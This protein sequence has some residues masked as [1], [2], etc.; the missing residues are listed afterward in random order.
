M[1]E[2]I[3]LIDDEEDIRHFLS[4]TLE[5]E[6]YEVIT[7]CNGQE[8]LNLFTRQ[9][10]DLVITDMRM[11][12]KD[13]MA[14]LK[15]IKATGSDVD[16]IM[17]TGHSDEN[18][19]IACLRQGVY[20]YLRK[21][22]EDLDLLIASV[23]RAIQKRRLELH[24]KALLHRLE[25]LAIKDSLTGL[26]NYRYL[27]IA[28]DQ[29]ILRSARF[30]HPFCLLMIDLDDFKQVNDTYGH[31]CGDAVLKKLGEIFLATVRVCDSVYRYGGEEFCLLM[32]ETSREGVIPVI[33]R[34]LEAI[35]F[36]H[37]NWQ[38]HFVRITV[39]IGGAAYPDHAGEKTALLQYADQALYQAKKEGKDRFVFHG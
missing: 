11:P 17:L 14:V 36:T 22:L 26:Y 12:Q 10:P 13:G 19:V 16:V 37:V 24:N 28:L 8:G 21:P 15:E 38:E 31:L 39:S 4:L 30:Q 5:D 34:L 35:R 23:R 3:L 20:D 1:R 2:K 32:P 27:Q 33:Q 7:A 18:M 25:E 6:G 29:E 9:S